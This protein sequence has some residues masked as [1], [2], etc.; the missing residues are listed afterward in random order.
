MGRMNRYMG[1]L[2]F[3]DLTGTGTLVG[4]LRH[5][6]CYPGYDECSREHWSF[7]HLEWC[8]DNRRWG[9]GLTWQR[10]DPY[11][12]DRDYLVTAR[13]GPLS[14]Y[15]SYNGPRERLDRNYK[16]GVKSVKYGLEISSRG[17]Y[18]YL[19]KNPWEWSRSDPWWWE[20]AIHPRDLLLGRLKYSSRVIGFGSYAMDMPEG[21]YRANVTMERA[22]WRR[23]RWPW[24][25]FTKA[26]TRADINLDPPI[27]VPGKGENSWDI[28]DDAVFD[29]MAPAESPEQ[30]I[31]ELREHVMETRRKYASEDW[32][33]DKGWP[34]GVER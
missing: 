1:G 26:V 5:G 6:H 27:P 29:S 32:V 24:W 9:L 10:E 21:Y 20:I 30:A 28:D 22:T 8:I 31:R 18:L 17:I 34:E 16:A 15:L 3:R 14:V 4:M 23:P 11:S 12:G 2:S 13:I 25:P 7:D 33:P 19:G